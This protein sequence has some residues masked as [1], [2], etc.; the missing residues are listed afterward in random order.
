MQDPQTNL[1]ETITHTAAVLG[2][3][4]REIRS[5]LNQAKAVLEGNELRSVS[6]RSD[7]EI[8][9]GLTGTGITPEDI[10]RS[11]VSKS[12]KAPDGST[13][14]EYLDKART[15]PHAETQFPK[16]L[17]LDNARSNEPTD[18]EKEVIN[19]LS[20]MNRSERR[21]W[22]AKL[23]IKSGKIRK[24]LFTVGKTK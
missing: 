5:A 3:S 14:D 2:T 21:A 1:D 6:E 15:N 4:E 17:G 18:L 8:R 12:S 22:L 19:F 23:R 20:A 9:L 11:S 16:F 13:L 7:A 24:S 10:G